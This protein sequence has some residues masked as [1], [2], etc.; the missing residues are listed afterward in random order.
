MKNDFL[1]QT[2]HQLKIYSQKSKH[3]HCSGHC[4][5]ECSFLS[6]F[7]FLPIK[8][9]DMKYYKQNIGKQHV[10]CQQF[11]RHT[12]IFP[13]SNPE[14]DSNIGKYISPAHQL[15]F[16]LYKHDQCKQH[17]AKQSFHSLVIFYATG[18][19]KI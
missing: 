5:E 13:R 4:R 11:H 16:S 15:P 6:Q 19:R 3:H 8:L 12:F 14:K 17:D 18:K 7:L 10:Y 1:E 9:S 2:L